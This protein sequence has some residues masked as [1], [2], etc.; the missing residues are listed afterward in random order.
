[1]EGTDCFK[2]KLS[3]KNGDVRY[4][5]LD[6]DSYLE[7]KTGKYKPPCA[8]RCK[9]SEAYF[10]DY[11]QGERHLLPVRGWNRLRRATSSGKKL[12]VEK[13]EIKHACG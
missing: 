12:S 2:V 10:G 9:K 8:E 7:L 13:I 4:Y 5:Y 6:T 11:E 1:V 3:M